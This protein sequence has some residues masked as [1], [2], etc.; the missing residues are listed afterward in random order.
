MVILE[1]WFFSTKGY[2]IEP[3]IKVVEMFKRH[4]HAIANSLSHPDSNA[5]A[6]R[7]N[8]SIQ[9]LKVVARGFQ[10]YPEFQNSHFIP[11]W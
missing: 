2:V 5:Y 10:E 8:R 6:E 4:K 7:M 9:E 3:I 1:N 11:L